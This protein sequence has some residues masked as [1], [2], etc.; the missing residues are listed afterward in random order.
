ML[1]LSSGPHSHF[2]F[3][4]FSL[5]FK[6]WKSVIC[7]SQAPLLVDSGEDLPLRG[8]DRREMKRQEERRN[9]LLFYHFCFGKGYFVDD[10]ASWNK[11]VCK[12]IVLG[13]CSD[14]ISFSSGM[15]NRSSN[16][17]VTP[18]ISVAAH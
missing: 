8:T 15:S 6:G 13:K 10:W 14:R 18:V 4:Y 2:V 5:Y 17:S 1:V 9:H 16:T 12:N 7:T 11:V 3:L